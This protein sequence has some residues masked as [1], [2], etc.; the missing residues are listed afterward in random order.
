MAKVWVARMQGSRGFE[1]LLAVKMIKTEHALD[2]RFEAMFLDEVGI[3]SRIQHPNVASILDVGEQDG[4]LYLVMELVDGDSLARTRR[5][6]AQQGVRIPINV[7]LRIVA[8]ACA[9]LHAAHEL[10]DPA[11]R[12]MEVIHR[13]VSPQNILVSSSG[14]VKIIDFGIA[15]ARD[16]L[17]ST[18]AGVLKGKLQYM[19][20]EQAKGE[21]IDR[22]VDIW[23]LGVI[24][25][26]LFAGRR[27]FEARYELDVLKM[28]TLGHAPPALPAD[29]PAAA[30]ELVSHAL[31]F[32]RG[33]RFGNAA[34][35]QRAIENVLVDLRMP[36]TSDDV[37]QFLASYTSELATARRARIAQAIDVA[38]DEVPTVA[39]PSSADRSGPVSQHGPWAQ[40]ESSRNPVASTMRVSRE[41]LEARPPPAPLRATHPAAPPSVV[42]E[43]PSVAT[44]VDR[45]GRKRIAIIAAAFVAVGAAATIGLLVTKDDSEKAPSKTVSSGTTNEEQDDLDPPPKT[46]PEIGSA[47][48]A[49]TPTPSPV[50]ESASAS[51]SIAKPP[52]P[53]PVF[54]PK[55]KPSATVDFGY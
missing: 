47:A 36:T 43:T 51:A 33:R 27:P 7:A 32:H 44:K 8:D 12:T 53:R 54:K 15:K 50:V 46:K 5:V 37:A 42:V 48:P 29:V 23:A 13:D 45:R 38:N 41:P 1:R 25:Y 6:A 10:R 39:L 17:V 49:P 31:D 18:Q 40:A 21:P 20:P 9:G 34:A 28:L 52:A 14:S 3:A 16:R 30:V 11:G 22:R 26:E 35:L 24:M 19:A 2:K 55:P 4:V